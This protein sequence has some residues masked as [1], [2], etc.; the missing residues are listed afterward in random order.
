MPEPP[1]PSPQRPAFLFLPYSQRTWCNQ[2]FWGD[3]GVLPPLRAPGTTARKHGVVRCGHQ[4]TRF[5]TNRQ[6][7]A[8]VE[9]RGGSW[10]GHWR[11]LYTT[12]RKALVAGRGEAGGR[13]GMRAARCQ[14]TSEA[15]P[16]L[17]GSG[18]P[19]AAE[20]PHRIP[21]AHPSPQRPRALPALAFPT[22]SRFGLSD[23]RMGT[24][25]HPQPPRLEG[26]GQERA[27]GGS[28]PL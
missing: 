5:K 3:W 26:E 4:G 9:T 10:W 18:R 19:R 12:N 27:T 2:L 8:E 16:S 13:E 11:T 24:A 14:G 7:Q 21:K 20:G 23:G 17:G 28:R 6:G 15:P 25:S 22:V 1:I